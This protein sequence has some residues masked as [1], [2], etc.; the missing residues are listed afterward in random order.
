MTVIG[1]TT[2]RCFYCDRTT[3]R[4]LAVKIR[5]TNGLLSCADCTAYD[6][7]NSESTGKRSP[8]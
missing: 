6:T 7:S 4:P 3:T 5:L 8:Q 2:F 1:S